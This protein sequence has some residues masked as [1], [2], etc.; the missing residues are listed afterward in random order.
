MAK[1]LVKDGKKE[2]G[3][4]IDYSQFAGQGFEDVKAKDL[5]IPFLSILQK[6]SPQVDSNHSEY[7]DGAKQGELFNTVS[8]ERYNKLVVVP[9]FFTS[10]VVEWKPERG[11]FVASHAHTAEIVQQAR[12]GDKN[13]LFA[14]NG[15]ELVDTSYMH[16]LYATHANSP[17]VDYQ[18]I[19]MTFTVTQLKKAR[20]WITNAQKMTMDNGKPFPLFAFRYDV[21]TLLEANEK[22]NWHGYKITRSNAEP[23]EDDALIDK[24]ITHYN[25]IKEGLVNLAYESAQGSEPQGQTAF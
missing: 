22:Y 6:L 13:K 5:Q 25:Q 15:N 4:M 7:I 10:A 12:K 11:G 20:L 9:L 3:Q 23:I 2:I 24:A 1:E 21:E 19:V 16:V 14:K 18:H 17:A 8:K